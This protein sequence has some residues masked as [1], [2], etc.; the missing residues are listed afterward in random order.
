MPIA[1]GQ[2]L[3][4]Q[5]RERPRSEQ[6]HDAQRHTAEAVQFLQRGE[7]GIEP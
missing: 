6:G 4:R 7:G 5:L 2:D 3:G 1:G